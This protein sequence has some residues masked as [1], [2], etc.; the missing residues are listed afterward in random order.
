MM[1]RF[2]ASIVGMSTLLAIIFSTGPEQHK[3]QAARTDYELCQEVEVE[4]QIAVEQ[5][6]ITEQEARRI[7]DRCFDLF[8]GGR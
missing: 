5:G 1:L 2:I 3:A 4:L 7:T 8:A 6:M